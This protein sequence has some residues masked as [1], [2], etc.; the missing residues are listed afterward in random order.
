MLKIE[1]K[2]TSVSEISGIS[3]AGKPYLIRKQTAWAHTYNEH[4]ALNEYPER[5]DINL[6]VDQPAFAAG[7]Y[8]LNPSCIFVGDFHQLSIGRVV[9]DSIQNAGS[10]Q[11]QKAA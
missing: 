11:I 3:K 10:A 1:I 8:K 7:F 4:G 6:A 2:S 9:I 5:F